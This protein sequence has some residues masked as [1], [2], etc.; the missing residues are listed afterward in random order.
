MCR[1]IIRLL[2]YEKVADT[3][4]K[5]PSERYTFVKSLTH[6]NENHKFA[7]LSP[8]IWWRLHGGSR[9]N[10]HSYSIKS[11]DVPI[12]SSHYQMCQFG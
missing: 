6:I 9:D 4:F 8:K 12:V 5:Y 10:D 7:E 1:H 11:N 2:L 3:P